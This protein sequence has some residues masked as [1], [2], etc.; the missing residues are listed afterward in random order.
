MHRLQL[1]ACASLTLVLLATGAPTSSSTRALQQQL[2]HLLLDLQLLQRDVE[3]YKNLG[4][5]RIFTFK[6]YLPK[7]ATEL[8]HLHCLAEE[9][10]SLEEVLNLAQGKNSTIKDLMNNINVTV[11]ELKGAETSF[12]CDYEDEAVSLSDFLTRW[13][14]SCQGIFSTLA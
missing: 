4:V 8:K 11:L 10:Q 3:N 12:T 2:E 9:L 5:P 13:I 7:K 6:F 14:T 1:L